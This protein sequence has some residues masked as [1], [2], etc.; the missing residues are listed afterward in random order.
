MA[1]Q[2]P[3]IYNDVVIAQGNYS[4]PP[5]LP[6]RSRSFESPRRYSQRQSQSP[7]TNNATEELRQLNAYL[8][9][10]SDKYP[11]LEILREH[12]L[13]GAVQQLEHG[14][15]D[16]LETLQNMKNLLVEMESNMARDSKLRDDNKYMRSLIEKL[17]K[18]AKADKDDIKRLRS[19]CTTLESEKID[20]VAKGRREME[21][22][23]AAHR[24]EMTKV[25][26]KHYMETSSLKT[27]YEKLNADM[28]TMRKTEDNRLQR[29]RDEVAD[30]WRRDMMDLQHRYQ[31]DTESSKQFIDKLNETMRLEKAGHEAQQASWLAGF[32]QER[33][34]WQDSARVREE[35][36]RQQYKDQIIS[37]AAELESYKTELTTREHIDGLT[38]PEL[39]E[40]FGLLA[41]AVR[42]VSRVRWEKANE[43]YWPYPESNIGRV[44]NPRK[45]KQQIVQACIWNILFEKVFFTPFQ[46]FADEGMIMHGEWTRTYGKDTYAKDSQPSHWPHP[47]QKSEAWRYQKIKSCL[48]ALEQMGTASVEMQRCKDGYGHSLNEASREISRAIEKLCLVDE[49]QQRAIHSLVSQAA[50]FWLDVGSQH[51]RVLVVMPSST[52]NPL[53][54]AKPSYGQ[55]QLII[56]PKLQ[57]IGN[58]VGEA[59][60][61]METVGKWDGLCEPYDLY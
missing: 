44:P 57:R 18:E 42:E 27:R 36:I 55:I 13:R 10:I 22:A 23:L 51:Y 16:S 61:K 14:Y 30:S 39:S 4:R 32:D 8:R 41:N 9:E 38:D 26:D 48:Q 3:Q 34:G 46:V 28:R 20:L 43:Q 2:I 1:V 25:N 12:S 11:T 50:K 29:A 45:L 58:A 31:E 15:W 24:A 5:P 52:A 49:N 6:T 7:I 60:D 21:K 37:M 35:Q 47:T 54:E 33:Q 40:Q 53:Q 19:K 17:Q 56:N 59:L